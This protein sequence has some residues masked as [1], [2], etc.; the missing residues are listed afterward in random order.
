M[1]HGLF[2]LGFALPST[3]VL[4]EPNETWSSSY[5]QPARQRRVLEECK[6]SSDTNDALLL[7]SHLLIR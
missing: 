7:R 1:V 3:S 5:R 4:S 2:R 6:A